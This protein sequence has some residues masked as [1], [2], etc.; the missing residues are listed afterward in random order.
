MTDCPARFL[1]LYCLGSGCVHLCV[2][3]TLSNVFT[4]SYQHLSTS[5]WGSCDIL[6]NM[7]VSNI[8][9]CFQ[10][11]LEDVDPPS[12]KEPKVVM[13]VSNAGWSS[14]LSSAL[15]GRAQGKGHPWPCQLLLLHQNRHPSKVC[16]PLAR[17]L[18]SL[19]PCSVQSLSCLS[20]SVASCPV[21]SLTLNY[22]VVCT[23]PLTQGR[24]PHAQH[25]PQPQSWGFTFYTTSG[26]LDTD[27]GRVNSSTTPGITPRNFVF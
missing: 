4:A 12:A 25:I 17:L 2:L 18:R 11:L 8:T 24:D 15:A 19:P 14:A 26:A 1:Q 3:L 16:M 13:E 21:N 9:G 10:H 23:S 27:A 20:P 6:I 5:I 7:C 22:W